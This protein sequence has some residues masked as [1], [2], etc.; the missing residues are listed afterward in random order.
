MKTTAVPVR[1]QR[2]KLRGTT[3][4]FTSRL[5]GARV[6]KSNALESLTIAGFV[7]GLSVRDV[8][9]APSESS[10]SRICQAIAEQFGT[11]RTR[12]LNLLSLDYLF[13]DGSHFKM[14]PGTPGARWRGYGCHVPA[15]RPKVRTVVPMPSVCHICTASSGKRLMQPCDPIAALWM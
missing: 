2:P 8:E 5:L 15:R 4:A 12:R 1:F 7:R 3:E 13:L 11:W 10:V 14:H 6:S 9:A